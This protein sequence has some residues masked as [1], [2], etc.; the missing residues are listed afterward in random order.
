MDS[1]PSPD[2]L[3]ERRQAL[4][5]MESFLGLDCASSESTWPQPD[6]P[7]GEGNGVRDPGGRSGAAGLPSGVPG[8]EILGELGRGGMGVVYRA[9]Q[10]SLKRVVALKMIQAGR[11]TRPEQ[12]ARFR[13]EAEAVARLQHPNIVQVYETG[14]HDGL[15]YFSLEFVDG[16][17]LDRKLA[18][19][20]L[21]PREAAR[22]VER[23]A[24]AMAHAHQCGILHRDLKPANVLLAADGTPKITDFGLAKRLEEE[25]GHTQTGSIFGTPPYM[26][27]EQAEGRRP[28]LS[29]ATDVYALGAI[30]YECLTGRPPFKGATL[31]DTLE[32]VRTQEP[33]PPRRLQPRVPRELDTIA[34]KRLQK[35]PTKRYESA[36]ALAEDL[37]RFLN[38][39][40]IWARPVTLAERG[41]KWVRRRP[42]LAA[43]YSL[44]GLALLL[45]GLGGGATWLWRRAE[46]VRAELAGEKKRSDELLYFRRVGLAL[47]Q[48]QEGDVSR[49]ERLL[50]NCPEEQR[51]WEWRYVDRLCHSDLVTLRGNAG[52]VA[53]LAFSPDGSR[54][55]SALADGTVRVWDATGCREVFSF[56]GHRGSLHSPAFSPDGTRLASASGDGT[57]ILWDANT[58]REIR[59]LAGHTGRVNRMAFSPDGRYLASAGDDH[60]AWIWDVQT[61]KEVFTLRGQF[62]NVTG[63]AFS[64]DGRRLAGTSSSRPDEGEI[65]F[66]DTRTGKE[67]RSFRPPG[68]IVTVAFSPDGKC[69]AGAGVDRSVRV[70]DSACGREIRALWGHTDGLLGVAFSPDG[71]RLA[72]WGHDRMVKVWETA[73]GR[74]LFAL[75]G[76]QGPV[77]VVAFSPDGTR[78]A[79]ASADGT[80]KLW[81][82]TGGQPAVELHA[83]A[84]MIWGV[85]FDPAGR[86]LASVGDDGTVKVW[87]IST[88]RQVL[89]IPAHEKAANC[90]AFSRDGQL[91]AS[92]GEKGLVKVWDAT[93]GSLLLALPRS[94]AQVTSIAL[95]PDGRLLASASAAWDTKRGRYVGGAIKVWDFQTGQEAF[96]VSPEACRGMCVAFS[97]DGKRLAF[98]GD[99]TVM[100]YEVPTG[101]PVFSVAGHEDLVVS[102][103]FSPDGQRL[104][105]AS[106][107][108][109]VKVWDVATGTPVLTLEGHTARVTSVAFSPDGQRLASG[110]DDHTIRLFTAT[111]GEEVL[112]L[113]AGVG[114]VHCLAFSPD[115]HRLAG[116][117][118]D[119]VVRVWDARPV[120][121][122]GRR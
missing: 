39:E 112:S 59:A 66:W 110:C 68:G 69:L 34:L 88:R 117:G 19:T 103:A 116:G 28:E 100:V 18:G 8:Y 121:P 52:G 109:T 48:W 30:L 67:V 2:D 47:R 1:T 114:P 84:G 82:G 49:A 42:A 9:R 50:Q 38:G 120:E 79:S 63:L 75:R 64:P 70:W 35:E 80:V 51:G 95:S 44:L 22:L 104:A 4:A 27:P 71:K 55:A 74:E 31:L 101:R 96:A 57:V 13:T 12:V 24:R 73:T 102:V 32:Q 118:W 93:T 107:D 83:H 33:V 45:G 115:G 40:P 72:S 65:K 61:G 87:D 122:G 91:L 25:S 98:G 56:R 77:G 15:P 78:L 3:R 119:G 16:G 99:G 113:R 85:S 20:P 46:E 29:P 97:P 90:V 89:S 94:A 36:L 43:A 11:G 105:S 76:H 111:S 58:G 10:V 6:A 21:P 14:E 5:A 60:A 37:R 26:A 17:S 53:A 23:L 62:K 86:R 54:I 92:G 81:D 106:W 41:I 108:R 7:A